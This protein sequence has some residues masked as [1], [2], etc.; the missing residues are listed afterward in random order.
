MRETEKRTFALRFPEDYPD[1]ELNFSYRLHELTSIETDPH[2]KIL[3]LTDPEL[4]DY[5]FIYI[6]EPGRFLAGPAGQKT[7]GA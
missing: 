2:G 4:F 3:E 7:G 1:A 5:P 6:I